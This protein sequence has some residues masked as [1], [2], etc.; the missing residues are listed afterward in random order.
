MAEITVLTRASTKSNRSLRT[1]VPIG[2]VRQF[3]LVDGDRLIWELRAEEGKLV[4][5]LRPEKQNAKGSV[6]T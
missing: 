6:V 4:I 5:V 1:T 2:I 3:N